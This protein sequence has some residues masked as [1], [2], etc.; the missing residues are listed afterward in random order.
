[1]SGHFGGDNDSDWIPD[2]KATMTDVPAEVMTAIEATMQ[3]AYSLAVADVRKVTAERL[4]KIENDRDAARGALITAIAKAIEAARREGERD[5]I[6]AA[7]F[8]Q[9]TML[10]RHRR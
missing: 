6:A 4:E 2:R 3:A 10:T 9:R 5:G 8:A 7:G 1:M